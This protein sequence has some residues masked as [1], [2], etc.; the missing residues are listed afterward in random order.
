MPQLVPNEGT[1]PVVEVINPA[2]MYAF[3]YIPVDCAELPVVH[4]LKNVSVIL[5]EFLE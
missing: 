5:M 4:R 2:Q 3:T 1:R